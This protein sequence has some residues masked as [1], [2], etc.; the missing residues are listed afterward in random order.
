MNVF[1]GRRKYFFHDAP[2]IRRAE[3]SLARELESS[4]L[5]VE[6]LSRKDG[7]RMIDFAR[8]TSAMRYRELH[9]FTFGDPAH[10]LRADLR[11]RRGSLRIWRS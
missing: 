4:K 3:V 6:K 7:E 11:A 9:G 2:L 10:V 8:Q 1:P 5:L